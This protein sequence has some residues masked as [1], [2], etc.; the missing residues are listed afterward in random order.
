MIAPDTGLRRFLWFGSRPTCFS[1]VPLSRAGCEDSS[2]EGAVWNS[3]RDPPLSRLGSSNCCRARNL[4]MRRTQQQPITAL[5]CGFAVHHHWQFGRI[6]HLVRS[7]AEP[8]RFLV[9]PCW[10]PHAQFI[11]LSILTQTC[12][13]EV[14]RLW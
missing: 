5:N 9:T 8:R 3:P 7:K 1:E 6:I 14:R 12:G 4:C 11:C 13:H 2:T 10:N